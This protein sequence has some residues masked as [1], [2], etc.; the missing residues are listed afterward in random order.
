MLGLMMDFPLTLHAIMRRARELFP[1]R[2]IVSREPDGTLTRLDYGTVLQRAARLGSAL[3]DLGLAPGDRVATLCWNH[4]RHLEAYFGVP[5]AGFVL[6]TLNL[7]L[8][9]QDLAY[10]AQDAED[11]VLIVDADLLPVA[12]HF[13]PD[14]GIR[15][16]VVCP[17]PEG[18][19]PPSPGIGYEAFLSAAPTD[20][21]PP[22]P[23]EHTAAAMCYTSGT[24]GRP[25]GVVYSHRSLVLHS[26]ATA[27]PDVF[28]IS[29]RDTVLA[30]VPMFHANAWG[31]PY[32]A[33]LTGARQVL[34]R[35]ALDPAT[36][37]DLLE[38]ERV[39]LTA[40]VPT[41]WLGVL[42]EWRRRR[43]RP[44]LEALKAIVVGGGAC[45]PGLIRSYEEEVGV[46]VVTS[47]GMTE[48]TP[49]GTIGRARPER[50]ESLEERTRPGRPLP[51]VEL[52]VTRDGKP[53]LRDGASEGELEVR[54]PWVAASYYRKDPGESHDAGWFRTG[55]IAT[56]DRDGVLKIRD[57][58]KDLIKSGGEWISSVALESALMSHPAVQEAAVI[59]VPHPRWQ[60]RPLAVVVRRPDSSCTAQDLDRHLSASFP[61]WY[62]PDRYEFV[63]ELPKTGTGKF[64]KNE[65]RKRYAGRPD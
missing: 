23:A 24:T 61:D 54:G 53:C 45:P 59:A 16:V 28:D 64:R 10:I 52:R 33:A 20:P 48:L 50:Q 1:A 44:R 11:R 21:I 58:A 14:T 19:P 31:L 35:N 49:V 29:E 39:T 12:E 27:L 25:K 43:E 32:T 5:A 40:G 41:I 47:W 6:H 3:R 18:A 62:L 30:A 8:P 36:L 17:G 42:E 7:R 9:V 55:D 60:E 2:S 15:H 46:P 37:L 57:R 22:D 51:L 34:P 26:L 13:L 38:G 63:T 56:L 4:H 65:L